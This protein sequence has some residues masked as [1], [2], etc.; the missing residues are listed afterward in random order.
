MTVAWFICPYKR[1]VGAHKPTRYCSMDDFTA[2]ILADGGTWSETEILGDAALVK[3]RA[4]DSTLTTINVASGMV[5]IPNH[6]ALTDTLGDLSAGQRTAI[7]NKL[8]ALGYTLAELR[9]AIP[10]G[11]W[12]SVTLG[13]V[14]R[15]AA[16]RRLR[17]RYDNNT[18]TIICDGQSDPVRPVSDVDGSVQ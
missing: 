11:G 15:F 6:F 5:R 4:S 8:Q 3:V 1:R 7:E 16:S 9:A 14:L 2:A 17:P 10:S 18:D 13:Q 12:A